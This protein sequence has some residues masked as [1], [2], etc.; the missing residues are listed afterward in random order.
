MQL[1]DREKA[2]LDGKAGEAVRI[3]MSILTDVG[4]AVEAEK[5]AEIVHVHTD[6]G[7]YLDENRKAEVL[8]K[9]QNLAENILADPSFYPLLGYLA[10]H[11]AGNKVIA[12]EGIPKT[13]S[14]D[15][16]KGLGAAAASSGSIALFHVIGVTPEAHTRE[17]C[18]KEQSPRDAILVTPE[19]IKAMEEKLW[20]TAEERI[21]WVGFGC[22]HFSFSE[23][24]E[25]AGLIK[26]QQVHKSVEVTVFTSRNIHTWIKQLGILK[27]L[28]DAGIEV[29]TDGCLL[30][31]PQ[32]MSHTGTMMT[33]SAKA[34]NYIYSQAGLK[35]AYGSIKD[36]VDSAI[37]GKIIC[38]GSAWLR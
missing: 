8:I 9:C 11:K 1:T 27:I 20:T 14:V 10:G 28:K 34:A 4:A 36:C 15:N 26:G 3:A 19:M 13:V 35:A 7:F 29:F 2:M 32:K 25:L 6:S 31:Y 16:L 18:L 33:N 37:E 12:I 23:F 21:E 22:P 38:R 30:L 17:I 5:M 24:E